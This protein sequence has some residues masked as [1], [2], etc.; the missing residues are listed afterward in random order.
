[1]ICLGVDPGNATA[2]AIVEALGGSCKA[3]ACGL[4]ALEAL[5]WN[6]TPRPACAIVE[7]PRVYPGSKVDPNDLITLALSAGDAIGFFRYRLR[8]EAARS[9]RLSVGTFAQVYHSDW[10]GKI[11][12][13]SKTVAALAPN[14]YIVAKRIATRCHDSAHLTG[15]LRLAPSLEHNVWDAIGIAMHGLGFT[16]K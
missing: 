15:L 6:A 10:K 11:P 16:V 4:G 13:P 14:G 2:W 1:M 8:F 7:V 5:D 3:L 9:P 12:K